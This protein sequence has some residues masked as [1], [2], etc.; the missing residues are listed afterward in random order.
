M[1]THPN[2]EP[3]TEREPPNWFVFPIALAVMT[4]IIVTYRFCCT[5]Y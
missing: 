4:A 2:N 5:K 3:D 1:L